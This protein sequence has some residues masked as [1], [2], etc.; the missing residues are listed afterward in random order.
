MGRF[1][2]TYV[3]LVPRVARKHG[4]VQAPGPGLTVV[5]L[6]FLVL[7]QGGQRVWCAVVRCGAVWCGA[8]Q[9]GVVWC[10]VVWCGVVWCGVVWCGVV[11]CGVVWCG[12]VWCGVVWCGVVWCGVLKAPLP[13]GN[14]RDGLA[15]GDMQCRTA[16][17][18]GV[19][20][21]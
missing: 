2:V 7:E 15:R 18:L 3:L 12:V 9:F 6:S 4:L 19:C 21:V 5:F 20:C 11:W 13:S 17:C 14:G 1:S 10:G 8:V 16:V